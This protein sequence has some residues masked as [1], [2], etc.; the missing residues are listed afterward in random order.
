MKFY[1]HVVIDVSFKLGSSLNTSEK[2][3]PPSIIGTSRYLKSIFDRCTI[4]FFL[5][6]YLI[7]NKSNRK[8]DAELCASKRKKK[9]N[10]IDGKKKQT[11]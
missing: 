6:I 7:E 8:N 1:P 9:K 5:S 11:C 10:S 2:N 4:G 3:I